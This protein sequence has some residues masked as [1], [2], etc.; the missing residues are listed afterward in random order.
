LTSKKS[1]DLKKNSH[2]TKGKI[3][4]AKD[5]QSKVTDDLKF[6]FLLRGPYLH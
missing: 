2:L 5:G 6:S 1:F 4:I 3:S